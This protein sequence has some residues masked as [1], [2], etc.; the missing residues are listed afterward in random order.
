MKKI[1]LSLVALTSLVFGGQAFAHVSY[2]SLDVMNPYTMSVSSDFGWADGADGTWGNSHNVRWFSFSLSTAQTV[3]I[4]VANAGAG[5]FTNYTSS[6]A[7][8]GTFTSSGD[9]DP[10]FSLY[11]GL[12]P[13]AAYENAS[14]DH[15]NDSSTPNV[16]VYPVAGNA[17]SGSTG[18]FN[19]LGNVTLGNNSGVIGTITYL[20]SA[21]NYS[22]TLAE[23]LIISLSP[24]NYSIAAGGGNASGSSTSTFAVTA[25]IQPVP[26][27]AAA[28]LFGGA[29]LTLFRF[30]KRKINA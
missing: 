18:L 5:V 13:A 19:A 11:S 10:A 22:G 7:A 25:S 15:D 16:P 29:M 1:I 23:T 17:P 4:T 20:G 26:I 9:I 2:R 14:W 28:W 3:K 8:S 27:P 24:G 12:L 6:N 30:G 21:N